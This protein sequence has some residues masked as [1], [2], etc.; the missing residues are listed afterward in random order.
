MAAEAAAEAAAEE[1]AQ[2]LHQ[3]MEQQKAARQ[4]AEASLQ[5]KLQELCEALKA[6][7][8][9]KEKVHALELANAQLLQQLEPVR[10][11]A[12]ANL[13]RAAAHWP[14]AIPRA[15]NPS[16]R[17]AFES[18]LPLSAHRG[19]VQSRRQATVHRA[20]RAPCRRRR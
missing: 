1:A 9:S 15:I 12:Q 19:G 20:A 3:Q 5:L 18:R 6:L 2:Q 14:C 10:L 16:L 13:V 8:A 7:E 4:Q 17:D 11:Q